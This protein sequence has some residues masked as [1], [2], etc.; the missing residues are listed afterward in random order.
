VRAHSDATPYVTQAKVLYANGDIYEGRMSAG[1]FNGQGVYTFASVQGRVS[2]GGV[3][4]LTQGPC[5]QEM[6]VLAQP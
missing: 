5:R 1:V 3:D 6:V 4:T 2:G